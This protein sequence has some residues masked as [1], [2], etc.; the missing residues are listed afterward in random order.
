MATPEGEMSLKMIS[1]LW[2]QIAQSTA[3]MHLQSA[4]LL[5]KLPD[6]VVQKP[7]LIWYL[8]RPQRS[9]VMP[10]ALTVLRRLLRRSHAKR[11]IF[12]GRRLFHISRQ[13]RRVWASSAVNCPR[14]DSYVA[15]AEN[16]ARRQIHASL[17]STVGRMTASRD[18]RFRRSSW[19]V[20][21]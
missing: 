1:F 12:K 20:K 16:V 11:R 14:K 8:G 6:T 4:S 21:L 13:R 9:I 3:K 7:R 19:I 10:P 18:C 15:L 2:V 5:N 17:P